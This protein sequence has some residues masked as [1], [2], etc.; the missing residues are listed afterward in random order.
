MAKILVVDDEEGLTEVLRECLAGEGHDA[1][2]CHDSTA[3]ERMA[4]EE[5]PD[6]AIIDYQMP[7]KNG[8]QLLADL[9]AKEET[10]LLPVL[11]I[12]GTEAVRFAGQIPPEPRV[13]FLLK[14]MDMDAFV[15]MVREMLDPD[16]WSARL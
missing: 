12:S 9:R 3:A 7:R 2:V 11:F 4:L 16:S 5:N 6:L 10:R 14:P 8:V 1:V 13:R 15:T